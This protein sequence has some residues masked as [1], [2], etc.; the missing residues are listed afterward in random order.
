MVS[1]LHCVRRTSTICT[2]E[3]MLIEFL[4]HHRS[5]HECSCGAV[6]K[7]E[8][9]TVTY[10]NILPTA[11]QLL[12]KDNIRLQDLVG[13]DLFDEVNIWSIVQEYV[14][15]RGAFVS[16]DDAHICLDCTPRN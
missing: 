13:L 5:T 14:H 7:G 1:F 2:L 9:L 11:T 4:L 15:C 12:S 6:V 16:G 10:G 3:S 8:W